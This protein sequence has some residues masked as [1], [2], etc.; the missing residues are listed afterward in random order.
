M[1]YWW[2]S[3]NKT[4]RQE[5]EGGYLWAPLTDARGAE[6]HH[7]AALAE[8]QAGDVVVS[9][10]GGAFVA[11]STAL[12][13]A[14]FAAKPAE[15]GETWEADGRLVPVAYRDLKRPLSLSQVV[16]EL[17]PLMPASQSPIT[18]VGR[19]AQGYLFRLPWRAAR[20]LLELLDD[21]NAE[22]V[23]EEAVA[24]SVPDE[25]TRR[26]LVESRVGQGKFRDDLR[27][28]WGDRCAVTGA[29]TVSLLRASHIK[30]WRDS[31]NRERLDPFNGLLLAPAYDAAFDAGLITFDPDGHVRLSAALS[32]P[33]AER[34]GIDPDAKLRMLRSEHRV[35]LTHH[36][37]NVFVEA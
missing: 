15:L 2:V 12:E 37:E 29:T 7:H 34:L 31:D 6:L 30:P 21:S 4:Y 36:V 33:E 22:D 5:R 14:R 20:R 1:A 17:L 9:Y 25:T 8:V 13:G 27:R 23:V 11:V 32:V 35:Y 24:G 3:Q 18:R 19:G 10:V 16:D 26:A 28:L